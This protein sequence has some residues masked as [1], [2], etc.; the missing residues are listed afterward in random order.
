MRSDEAVEALNS[1][2]IPDDHSSYTVQDY[3]G[4]EVKV[5]STSVTL[6]ETQF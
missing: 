3:A 2:M 1:T 4:Q 6:G 5:E